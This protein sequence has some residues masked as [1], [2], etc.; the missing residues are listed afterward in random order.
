MAVCSPLQICRKIDLQ[1][2]LTVSIAHVE[3]V[4]EIIQL[5]S[6]NYVIEPNFCVFVTGVRSVD[7][8]E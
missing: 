5:E 3:Y 7:A 8:G 4:F 6:G 2:S 1:F